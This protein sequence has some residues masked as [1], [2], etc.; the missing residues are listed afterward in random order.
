MTS[1]SR[2]LR[3]HADLVAATLHARHLDLAVA[4]EANPD[5]GVAEPAQRIDDRPREVERERDRDEQRQRD[6][7]QQRGAS[8][9]H[10]L[11]DV[12]GI[13]GGQQRG[14]VDPDRR[15]GGDHRRAVGS[16]AQLDLGAALLA[17][18]HD[19][20]PGVGVLRLRLDVRLRGLR[21]D[22]EVDR[23]VEPAREVLAPRRRHRVLELERRLGEREAVGREVALGIVHAQPHA[24]FLADL[25]QQRLLPLAR[26]SGQRLGRDLGLDPGQL[27]TLVEQLAAVGIEEEQAAGE[28]QQR[29]QVDRENAGG[30]RSLGR[31][32]DPFEP[33]PLA[34]LSHR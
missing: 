33:A 17:G 9:A 4:A 29:D 27:E 34:I 2:A 18:D 14:A 16:A 23:A 15:G 10:G 12:G 24:L 32:G 21:P 5:R 7:G 28:D 30:E 11:G 1:D 25:D 8:I 13:A 3:Q 20:G 22:Q 19:L 31:E 26:R 6:D